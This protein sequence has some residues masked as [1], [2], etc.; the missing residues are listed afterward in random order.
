M[1]KSRWLNVVQAGLNSI[2]TVFLRFHTLLSGGAC[3]PVPPGRAP[4][5]GRGATGASCAGPRPRATRRWSSAS[6]RDEGQNQSPL[7]RRQ[8]SR[9]AKP[10]AVPIPRRP[11]RR[12]IRRDALSVLACFVGRLAG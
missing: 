4:P 9:R 3:G 5:G 10:A 8:I 1:N 6:R 12:P 11:I 7:A 2:K